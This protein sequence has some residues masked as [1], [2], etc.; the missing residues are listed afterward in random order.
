MLGLAGEGV[1]A[2]PAGEGLPRT[3]T[4]TISSLLRSC[5]PLLG[6]PCRGQPGGVP[7]PPVAVASP[8]EDFPS[9]D[10]VMAFI[11]AQS[12]EGERDLLPGLCL[13]VEKVGGQG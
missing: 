5:A 9:R 3:C 12:P 11:R 10:G 6:P 4:A 1:G 8:R 7:A 13:F 2:C